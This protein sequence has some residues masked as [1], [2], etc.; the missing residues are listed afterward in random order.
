MLARAQD[1]ASQV[2]A[3]AHHALQV[4]RSAHSFQPSV[5]QPHAVIQR[6]SHAIHRHPSCHAVIQHL[7]CIAR[8]VEQ[9]DAGTLHVA[10]NNTA[11]GCPAPSDKG[12]HL[13]SAMQVDFHSAARKQYV[14]P[15]RFFNF[16]TAPHDRVVADDL[17]SQRCNVCNAMNG[18]TSVRCRAQTVRK[19]SGGATQTA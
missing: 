1:V 12:F 19:S 7:L 11:R 16:Q 14:L 4:R 13:A 2:T 5:N 15:V 9:P 6:V 3:D 18:R 8:Q 17:G 10:G